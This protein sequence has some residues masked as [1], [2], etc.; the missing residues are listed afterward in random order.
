MRLTDDEVT[1]LKQDAS[2]LAKQIYW[3]NLS[4]QQCH[5]VDVNN[6]QN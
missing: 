3:L 6:C 4:Y 1:L 2:L 5:V